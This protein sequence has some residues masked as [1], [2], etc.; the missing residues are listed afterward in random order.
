MHRS[1]PLRTSHQNRL[2]DR[3]FPNFSDSL[4]LKNTPAYYQI[5]SVI[6]SKVYASTM[7]AVFNNRIELKLASHRNT[8]DEN[9][10]AAALAGISEGVVYHTSAPLAE[11]VQAAEKLAPHGTQEVSKRSKQLNI[12]RAISAVRET[13]IPPLQF[14]SPMSSSSSQ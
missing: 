1:M 4:V 9:V 7:M 10:I 2:P 3:H 11:G 14:T 6:I 12:Q 13:P 8:D 5:T